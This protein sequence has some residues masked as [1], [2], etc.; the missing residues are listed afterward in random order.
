MLLP[1]PPLQVVPEHGV[2]TVA[3]VNEPDKLLMFGVLVIVPEYRTVMLEPPGMEPAPVACST[4]APIVSVKP[5]K[6]ACCGKLL[7]WNA[8][9]CPNAGAATRARTQSMKKLFTTV[10][11]LMWIISVSFVNLL[12][13]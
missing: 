10:F 5:S 6:R 3:I 2:G 12:E 8:T 1:V 13:S 11:L 4:T 9:P 7:A